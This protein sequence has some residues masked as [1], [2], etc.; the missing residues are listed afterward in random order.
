MKNY[1]ASQRNA[2][3]SVAFYRRNKIAC[4][5]TW[6]IPWRWT[7]RPYESRLEFAK[8]GNREWE[9]AKSYDE[10]IRPF[11]KDK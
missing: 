4:A 3:L 6:G 8:V 2:L 1:P 11:L 7:G 10:D 9:V 5:N